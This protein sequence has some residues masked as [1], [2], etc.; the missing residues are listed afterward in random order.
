MRRIERVALFIVIVL[1]IGIAVGVV[2][3]AVLREMLIAAV[4]RNN[5]SATAR[6]ITSF[7]P[8][9]ANTDYDN[10]VLKIPLLMGAITARNRETVHVLVAHGAKVNVRNHCR[11]TPLMLAAQWGNVDMVTLLIAHGA[12]VNA[13]D[14][15]GETALYK[16]VESG[17]FAAAQRL[18]HY[19]GSGMPLLNQA[20]A[21]GDVTFMRDELRR[22]P[23]GI[24]LKDAAGGT[25]LHQAALHGQLNA[26]QFLMQCGGDPVVK[27]NYGR[28]PFRNA[29]ASGNVAL[30]RLLLIRKQCGSPRMLSAALEA[31][32]ICGNPSVIEL[33][34]SSGADVDSRNRL[35]YTML[36]VAAIELADSTATA[37]ATVL[38][39]NGA[40]VNATGADGYTAL[41]FAAVCNKPRL[42]QLLLDNQADATLCTS[43]GETALQLAKQNGSH[44]ATSVL[45][46]PSV[47]RDLHIPD[48]I[49]KK[50][51]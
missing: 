1:G 50:G 15:G 41:H 10:G 30:V 39:A 18:R 22:D 43:A 32:V 19:G 13:V 28:T 23:R 24:F 6:R 40:A 37:L 4:L 3:K 21:E 46:R 51:D 7:V 49:L 48:P 36:E 29:A 44:A 8:S 47:V 17:H 5:N 20:A 12:K 33:L 31:A 16:A 34:I 38:L 9:L 35:G 2:A 27:D 45:S 26:A 25:A 11:Q 42:V 14:V